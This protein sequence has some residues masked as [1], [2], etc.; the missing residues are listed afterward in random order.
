MTKKTRLGT[1]DTIFSDIIVPTID[2]YTAVITYP[3]GTQK[4]SNTITGIVADNT[5]NGTSNID[6]APQKVTVNYVANAQTITVN[7]TNP[8]GSKSTNTISGTTD[9]SYDA[10]PI[11]Q[12]SGYSSNVSINGGASQVMTTVPAG[13]FG[14]TPIVIDVTYSGWQA[15]VN[16]Y[17]QQVDSS[18]SPIGALTAL[19][20]SFASQTGGRNE[21]TQEGFG[22]YALFGNTGGGVVTPEKQTSDLQAISVVP[23]GYHVSSYY[24]SNRPDGT[25]QELPQEPPYQ[26]NWTWDDMTNTASG[27]VPNYQAAIVYQ[28]TKD[29][30]QADIT[31]TNAPSGQGVTNG[32]NTLADMNN[33]PYTGVTGGT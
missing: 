33:A 3:D 22:F 21:T 2:G 32:K 15:Q 31:V 14:A 25:T 23:A 19:P 5:S 6:S 29:V 28:Y 11:T 26:I 18:G 27:L 20:G 16:Y 12:I 30:Q 10:I 24:W 4:N 1:T 8:D 9:G 7:Y 13:S 17:S